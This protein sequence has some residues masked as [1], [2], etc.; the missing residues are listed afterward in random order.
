[1]GTYFERY[2]DVQINFTSKGPVSEADFAEWR[3]RLVEPGVKHFLSG[4]MGTVELTSTQRREA[5]GIA[6]ERR[7]RTAVVTD[8]R[9]GRGLVT[10]VSWL[11]A[12]IA[13]F[14]WDELERAAEFLRVPPSERRRVADILFALRRAEVFRATG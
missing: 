8:D 9:V 3:R 14:S 4:A 13:A 7:I 12:D 5:A 1:M 11:G 10:A 2:D 6:K